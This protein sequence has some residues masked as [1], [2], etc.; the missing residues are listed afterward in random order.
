MIGVDESISR[1]YRQ[2]GGWINAGLSYYVT[3]DRKPENGCE[4]HD[5]C[6]A[7]SGIMMRLN[8][9]KEETDYSSIDTDEESDDM[10][11]GVKVLK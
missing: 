8:I 2:G 3:I 10:L 9:I 7:V 5:S 1:W 11:H 6:C 4:I